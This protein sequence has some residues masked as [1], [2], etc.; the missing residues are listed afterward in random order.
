LNKRSNVQPTH[1]KDTQH[2]C[3]T[4][5]GGLLFLLPLLIVAEVARRL[6]EFF[7]NL[8]TDGTVFLVKQEDVRSCN[9]NE[10]DLKDVLLEQG[11]GLV[12]Q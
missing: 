5:I 4:V 1:E 10:D 8:T 2:F 3:D 6:L 12:P 9:L 11:K 7:E